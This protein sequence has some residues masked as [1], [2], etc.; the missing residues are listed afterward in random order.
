MDASRWF[1]ERKF[2]F[3][4]LSYPHLIAPPST[5]DESSTGSGALKVLGKVFGGKLCDL[6][7]S[8]LPL[9]GFDL[10]I[11]ME[12]M[13]SSL[14]VRGFISKDF[15]SFEREFSFTG[16]SGEFVSRKCFVIPF[17]EFILL[18][19]LLLLKNL[20]LLLNIFPKDCDFFPF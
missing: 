8:D 5:F 16:S 10:V 17:G 19:R 6:G 3:T 1:I 9:D 20:I 18:K 4:P 15:A 11:I 14:G 7:K 13:G 12:N 2:R